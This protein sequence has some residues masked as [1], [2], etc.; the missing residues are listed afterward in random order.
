MTGVQTCALPISL[1]TGEKGEIVIRGGNVMAGYWMNPEATSASLKNGWLHTGDMGYLDPDGF[2]YVLGRFKSLLIADDG[3]KYSPEGMEELMM[4]Q[5]PYIEQCML[6]NNQ[7]PY[8]I[9]LVVPNKS[10]LLQYLHE[11][12]ADLHSAAGITLMCEKIESE[13]LEYRTGRKFGDLFPQRW[14]PAAIGI[15]P[16]A[17]TEENHLLNFQLK[18]VRGK[19]VE[20]YAELISALYT[21]QGKNI[22]NERNEKALRTLFSQES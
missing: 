20:R 21:P 2:L 4:A 8:T 14:L 3:E 10:M 1:G 16:E 6:Y 11:R 18:T 13:F 12:H 22:R 17:F 15:L 9:V 19:V 5:S 7:N